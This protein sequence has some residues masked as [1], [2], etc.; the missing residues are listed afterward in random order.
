MPLKKSIGARVFGLAIL[1]L[2]LTIALVGFLLWQVAQ[3]HRELQTLTRTN[4][5][6]ATSF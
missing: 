5:P 6:V 2:S 4:I 1:L 3:L